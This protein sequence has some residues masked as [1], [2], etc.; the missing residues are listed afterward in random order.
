MEEVNGG[1]PQPTPD[2]TAE[3]SALQPPTNGTPIDVTMGE[4]VDTTQVK[5]SPAAEPTPLPDAPSDNP[6]DAPGE[7]Q[8]EVAE[9]AAEEETAEDAEGETAEKVEDG[10]GEE[11]AAEEEGEDAAAQKATLEASARSHLATQTHSIILPSYSTWFNMDTVHPN[12]K[13]ALPEFFNNRNRSKTPAIYKDY[14]DFM[15][16]TYRLNPQEYLTFTACRRNLAGDVCAIMRVHA[17]LEQWGLI[18]FQIDPETRPSNIGPPFTGHFRV[19]V[20]TPR[21]LQPFQPAPRNAN[22]TPGKPHAS[23]Q[24][25]LSQPQPSASD[26]NLSI[27]QNI[28]DSA[29]KDVTPADH[30][31]PDSKPTSSEQVENKLAAPEKPIHCHSCGTDT[32]RTRFHRVKSAPE[33]T[34]GKTALMNKFDLCPMCYLDGRFP[35]SS[36]AAEYVKLETPGADKQQDRDRPWDD[37]ET[38][39]LLEALE[40][41]DQDWE[42]VAEHVGTRTREQCVL[43]FLQ[44][45]IEDKYVA[46]ESTNGEVANGKEDLR[47]MS[48]GHVPVTQSENPVMSV[49]SFLA[50]GVDP[51][52]AAAASGQAVGEMVKSM[53]EKKKSLAQRFSE[54]Q[55]TDGKSTDTAQA[56]GESMDVDKAEQTN[57]PATTALALAGARSFAMASH[58]ERQV[59][60]HLNNATA[61]QLEK[62]DLKLQQFNELEALLAA[63]RREI[64]RRT[65]ELFIERLQWRRKMDRVRDEVTRAISLGITGQVGDDGKLVPGSGSEG[66]SAMTEAL[67][68]LGVSGDKLELAVSAGL[69][70]NSTDAAAAAITG[71]EA[72]PGDDVHVM[73]MDTGMEGMAPPSENGD[74]KRFEI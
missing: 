6:L 64:E 30:N 52:V 74:A 57:D 34:S 12:E 25:R 61:L 32:T 31:D 22:L 54:A 72:T 41:F 10:E 48:G 62:L 66:L 58:V 33:S 55:S 15:I 9:N 2:A 51:A 28:Y 50:A 44:L 47:W 14:R 40:A 1:T 56:Q 8:P 69:K 60:S 42:A 43:K 5:K 37:R 73:P 11:E 18:N 23:T 7:P 29:G 36:T 49:L 68:T 26:L 65:K 35:E 53:D 17:F 71:I 24:R 20:D 27:R 4:E 59:S 38:L 70:K 46:G 19:I 63:E 21:G 39:M 16:N 45:E 13:K 3:P 67:G